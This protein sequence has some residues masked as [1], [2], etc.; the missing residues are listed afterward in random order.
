MWTE[1][2][3]EKMFSCLGTNGTL[4]TYCSKSAVRR[5]MEAAGFRVEKLPGP[6][7]KRDMVRAHRD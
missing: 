6:H 3:F 7:G 4:V 1:A 2:V 5:T